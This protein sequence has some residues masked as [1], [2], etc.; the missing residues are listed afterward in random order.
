M[1]GSVNNV[2]VADE[3][4]DNIHSLISFLF[5]YID[6]LRLFHFGTE[7]S[8]QRVPKEVSH[9]GTVQTK[10]CLTLSRWLFQL[11]SDHIWAKCGWISW[12]FRLH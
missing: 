8:V 1:V 10:A 9:S 11:P 12:C 6:I 5:Y 2:S 7:G 4:P 3:R